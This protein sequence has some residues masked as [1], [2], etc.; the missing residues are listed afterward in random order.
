MSAAC[1]LRCNLHDL[2]GTLTPAAWRA[3]LVAVLI[4]YTGP[5]VLVFQAAQNA[6]LDPATL[7]S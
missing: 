7:A 2:P 6:D 1:R 5:L 3:G 4:A